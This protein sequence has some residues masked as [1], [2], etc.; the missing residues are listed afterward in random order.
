MTA[1]SDEPRS[2]AGPENPVPG[3]VPDQRVGVEE[4]AAAVDEFLDQVARGASFT[5]TRDDKPVARLLPMTG[6]L[7]CER[8][9]RSAANLAE[10]KRA[11][12]EATSEQVLHELRGDH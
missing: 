10:L 6:E 2:S 11:R 8:P 3:F 12:T 9:A 7:A 5:L 1:G 4:F